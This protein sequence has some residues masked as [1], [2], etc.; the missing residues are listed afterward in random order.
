MKTLLIRLAV[1]FTLL[2]LFAFC[3]LFLSP[4]SPV[5][6][7]PATLAGDGSLVNYCDLPKLDGNGK[8][9]ANIPKI[10]FANVITG[11]VEARV[12]MTTTN[13]GSV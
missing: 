12:I 3:V 4:R 8:M 5:T 11:R 2:I 10:C 9:A 7:D 1:S 6:T 13:I